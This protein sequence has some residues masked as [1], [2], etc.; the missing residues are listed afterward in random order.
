MAHR[1]VATPWSRDGVPSPDDEGVLVALADLQRHLDV[2]GE[3]LVA[4]DRVLAGWQG[5][6]RDRFRHHLRRDL[7]GLAEVLDRLRR[8]DVDVRDLLDR[9]SVPGATLW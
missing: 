9:T 3:D 1:P 5:H 4:A 8:A 6:A 2:L 7:H